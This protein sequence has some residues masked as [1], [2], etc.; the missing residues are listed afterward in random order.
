ML[1]LEIKKTKKIILIHL[2][3]TL[4]KSTLLNLF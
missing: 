1:M 2:K 4:L 3:K